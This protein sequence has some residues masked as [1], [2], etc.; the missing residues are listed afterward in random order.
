L[1]SGLVCPVLEEEVSSM[2]DA[3]A[4]RAA[5]AVLCL[6]LASCATNP[7]TGKKQI[8][9][10]SEAQE[11]QM[12]QEADKE[13]GPSMGLYEDQAL[14]SYVAGIGAPLA[15]ASERP[16][17]PWSFKVVDD[18]SVNAFAIP[19]GFIYVTRGLMAHLNSEAEL[20]SVVGHEIG[21]VT[22]RHSISQISKSQLA[23][24]GLV[25]GMIVSPQLAR[26]GDL[27]QAGMGLL[28]MKFSRNDESQ[29]DDLGL[30]YITR[31]DYDP[32]EM[33][34]VFNVLDRVGQASG[35]GRMPSWLST[36]PAP[37]NR[38]QHIQAAIQ[39]QRLTGTRVVEEAYLRRLD[40]MVFGE[41]PREGF[42]E[43]TSFY[44]PELRFQITF[45]R[46]WQ[47][48]NQKQAVAAQSPQEDAIMALTL[49]PGRSAEQAAD[50]FL[51]Q[52][53]L[54]AG[55]AQRVRVGG[56]NAVTAVFEAIAGDTPVAGRVAFVEDGDKVYRILGYTPSSRF[57]S[58]D[59]A[60]SQAISSF[61]ELTERRYLDVQPRRVKVVDVR[62]PMTVEE[63]SRQHGSTVSPAVLALINHVAPGA[64]LPAG[65]PAKVV[66]GDRIPGEDRPR[67]R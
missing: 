52:E 29:A 19:G 17:L 15:A 30:R 10:V 51:R 8:M 37:E 62:Q 24:V 1:T 23:S 61:G 22:A 67:P 12:G 44:H 21:H 6:A 4:S 2:N 39:S 57:R 25:A 33:I 46:G 64:T 16:A 60:F 27:A 56:M 53:G 36:H 58:Y 5:G 28:F 43:G 13:V 41:N 38:A 7:A 63:L 42:F 20:A 50:Q 45:P 47:T 66:V 18:A 14:Q 48:Q 3:L 35:E 59:G 31:Q 34:E 54:R 40:G 26:F 32:R 49:A 11:I 9:L 55:Q 65:K